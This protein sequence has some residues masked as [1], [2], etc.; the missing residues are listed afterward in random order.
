MI[1]LASQLPSRTATLK[2]TDVTEL[3]ADRAAMDKLFQ[4][5]QENLLSDLETYDIQDNATLKGIYKDLV[6]LAIYHRNMIEAEKYTKLQVPLIEKESELLRHGQFFDALKTAYGE[7][8]TLEGPTFESVFEK[9]LYENLQGIPFEMIRDWVE[10]SKGYYQT[11]SENTLRGAE[12][13]QYQTVLNS[14]GTEVPEAFVM[15]FLKHMMTREIY[16]PLREEALAVYGR[17]LEENPVVIEE[18]IDIWEARAISLTNEK[19]LT[20]VVIGI[21]DGGTDMSV[22]AEANRFTNAKEVLD[23]EDNDNNGFIDDIHGIAFDPVFNPT[24]GL[25]LEKGEVVFETKMLQDLSKGNS[26]LRANIKSEEADAFQAFMTGLEPEQMQDFSEAMAWYG[27]YSHGTHVAGIAQ[28]GNP[29]AQ[30]LGARISFPYQTLPPLPTEEF[31]AQKAAAYQAYI[32]YFR[33]QGVRVVNMSWGYSPEYYEVSLALHNIGKD[34][35][36]RKD[37]ALTYFN[38]ERAALYSAIKKSGNILFI[39]AAGNSNNDA[40]FVEVIPSSLNLTNVLTVGAVD[41]EGKRTSF[42]TGGKSVDVYAN[43]FEVESF[44]PGG[45]RLAY[46]GTSMAAPQVANLAGKLLAVYPKLSTGQLIDYIVRGCDR[47]DEGFQLIHPKRSVQLLKRE[48]DQLE[49]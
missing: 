36:E 13:G 17:L 39:A 5:V 42:T 43:G 45:D 1:T 49:D 46:S 27:N 7:A 44:V 20:P 26:D 33:Q 8:T 2:T 40:D 16:L 30:V 6:W 31:V 29:A 22:F 34:P 21:W 11:L 25:L 15:A 9:T 37:L 35:E 41:S 4:Q 10:A 14:T 19:D 24:K 48:I 23:G 28:V 38:M 18:K 32:R 12:V 47:S 3:L